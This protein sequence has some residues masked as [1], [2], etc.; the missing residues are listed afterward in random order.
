MKKNIIKTLRQKSLIAKKDTIIAILQCYTRQ[1]EEFAALFN[2][3][4]LVDLIN[5]LIYKVE[6][7]ND[8]IEEDKD[9]ITALA[10]VA[11]QIGKTEE[12][13]NVEITVSSLHMNQS[14]LSRNA[15]QNMSQNLSQTS[16]DLVLEK[17]PSQLLRANSSE[18]IFK[19]V[20]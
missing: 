1:K 10:V 15:S 6:R 20:Q 7:I 13:K 9:V 14:D 12:P 19:K 5:L 18:V 2:K 11:T 4:I 16:P 3:G 17:L 8:C